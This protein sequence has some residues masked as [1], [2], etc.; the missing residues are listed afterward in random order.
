MYA[1]GLHEEDWEAWHAM[2][3]LQKSGSTKLIGVSNVNF[4]QVQELVDKS[5]IKPAFVQNRCF[6]STKWDARVREFCRAHDILY[7]GF[8]LLTANV[9]ELSQ[10]KV[11][12]IAKRLQCSVA[13]ATFRFSL[14]VG[15]IP[16]TG[17]TS[18]AH[19]KED[20]TAY[21]LE[22]SEEDVRTIE[23]AAF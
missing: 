17:T 9:A 19:M 16:L 7:Q 23:N 18:A 13:Q 22:L 4:D 15:M 20:L 11:V 14:Q 2:E 10:P 1:Q 21:D 6:A 8:S 5:E 12:A 3:V